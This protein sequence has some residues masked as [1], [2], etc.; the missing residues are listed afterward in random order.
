MQGA[1]DSIAEQ[2]HLTPRSGQ[3]HAFELLMMNLRLAEGI[4]EHRLGSSLALIRDLSKQR[5]LSNLIHF[6]DQK[7]KTTAIGSRLLDSVLSQLTAPLVD[8]AGFD[9]R[10]GVSGT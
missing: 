8:F 2:K 7:L 5:H 3:D 10:F 1:G 6:N 9:P 4:P